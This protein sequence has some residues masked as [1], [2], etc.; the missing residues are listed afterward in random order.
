MD[1]YDLCRLVKKNDIEKFKD[2]WQNYFFSK[3]IINNLLL[4]SIY[5]KKYKFIK[6]LA[7]KLV[8]QDH[9]TLAIELGD[10]RIIDIYW[11][12][13]PDC[14]KKGEFLINAISRNDIKIANYLISRGAPINEIYENHTPLET[15]I[16]IYSKN[17]FYTLLAAGADVNFVN[18]RDD[19]TPLARA[20]CYG[21]YPA[22]KILLKCGANPKTE[23]MGLTPLEWAIENNQEKCIKLLKKN[24]F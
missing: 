12:I 10:L 5:N 16:C 9:I 23:T 4:Q 7:V 11:R 8:K 21:N 17:I 15:A 22:L 24:D 19:G 20:A 1:Y 3:H 13:D 14:I 18:S 6:L 2:F